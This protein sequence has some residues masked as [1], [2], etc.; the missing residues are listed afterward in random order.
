LPRFE[1]PISVLRS[2]LECCRG[3]RPKMSAVL[4][5][6]AVADGRDHRCGGLGPDTSDP[7]DPLA[8]F[9]GAKDAFDLLVEGS[10]TTVEIPEQIVELVERLT[11][12]RGQLVAAIRQ[13]LRDRAP[14]PGDALAEAKPLSSRRPRI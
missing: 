12:E 4:E 9:A 6:G 3:T 5:L 14:R 2:P 7:R 8:G 1:M 13:D 11:G 10:D